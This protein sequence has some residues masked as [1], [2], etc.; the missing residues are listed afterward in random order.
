MDA[1][2][3]AGL[4]EDEKE[5]LTLLGY[6]YLRYGKWEKAV[7]IF[8]ALHVLFPDEAYFSK[9]LSF[10]YIR[11]E[12]Y[13]KALDQAEKFL[14][15]VSQNGEREIGHCLKSKALLGIGET[16]KARECLKWALDTRGSD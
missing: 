11:M 14:G 13:R 5:F 15:A 2:D 8:E 6:L 1:N 10:A 12:E 3:D 4:R 7:V 16:E 9:A